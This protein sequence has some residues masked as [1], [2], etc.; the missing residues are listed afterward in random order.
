MQRKPRL[1][2][3]CNS[4]TAQTEQATSFQQHRLFEPNPTSHCPSLVDNGASSRSWRV[5]LHKD[6]KT[7]FDMLPRKLRDRI[8]EYTFDHDSCD[9]YYRYQ[10]RAP[11]SYLR[12]VSRQFMHEYDEQT[13]DD[14]T[15]FVTG[16]NERFTCADVEYPRGPKLPRLAARCTSADMVQH[17]GETDGLYDNIDDE[18][19]FV[20]HSLDARIDEFYDFVTSL[21]S[22]QKS[23]FS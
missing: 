9:L 22:L 21:R 6:G 19:D 4:R 13:P 11:H 23:R 10:F 16:R 12:L 8:Y 5:F 1:A 7:F 14:A 20:F 2:F 17:I 18:D 15:L 3:V